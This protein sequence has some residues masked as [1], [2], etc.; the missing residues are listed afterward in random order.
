MAKF[1]KP[2]LIR[3]KNCSY[4]FKED[5]DNTYEID[6]EEVVIC[7]NCGAEMDKFGKLIYT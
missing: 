6:G 1:K 4:Q 7:V 5:K 3:C 2:K